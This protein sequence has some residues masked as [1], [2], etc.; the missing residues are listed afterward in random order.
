MNIIRS[1]INKFKQ[2]REMKIK[3]ALN[4]ENPPQ[5][6][7]IEGMNNLLK[8]KKGELIIGKV[9]RV[10]SN[11]FLDPD[12]NY[13]AVPEIEDFIKE[14]EDTYRIVTQDYARIVTSRYTEI[15]S[16]TLIKQESNA[17]KLAK[18]MKSARKDRGLKQTFVAQKI[19]VSPSCISKLETHGK[20]P[21]NKSFF[22][23][24]TLYELDLLECIELIK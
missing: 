5:L 9:T 14:G 21:Q 13:R 10:K 4:F 24:V 7:E 15:L 22:R 17:E 3:E 20:A 6:T 8:N 1:I 2:R 12:D 23:L 16:K 19:G 18:L 11:I